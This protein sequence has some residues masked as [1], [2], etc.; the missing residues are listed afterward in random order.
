MKGWI[1]L[2]CIL[3]G[4]ALGGTLQ[5]T[6][7]LN[8]TQSIPR[9]IYWKSPGRVDVGS[10]VEICV[11]GFW[12][13]AAARDYLS[14][15]DCPGGV[16]PVLKIVAGMPGDVVEVRG[17]RITVNEMRLRSFEVTR[18][19][20]NGE[21]V[22]FVGFGEHILGPDEIWVAGTVA[23]AIDSRIFGPVALTQARC[24]FRPVW[25]VDD[26]VAFR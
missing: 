10:V 1:A 20:G 8:Y 23:G 22:P 12:R 15:G 24:C 26:V 17:D 18:R 3:V 21:Y 25:V 16:G 11:G 13:I 5:S 4:M 2:G 6:V 14:S 19:D 7:A 9:G